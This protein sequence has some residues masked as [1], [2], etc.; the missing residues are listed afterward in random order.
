MIMSVSKKWFS[1]I[2]WSL[3]LSI[4][5]APVAMAADYS[6]LKKK[7]YRTSSLT[8]NRGGSQGWIVSM[9]SERYFCRLITTIV[10]VDSKTMLAF[11]SSGSAIPLDRA[12]FENSAGSA[13]GKFPLWSD[14]KNGRPE[15]RDVG[16]CSKLK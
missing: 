3:T 5:S 15:K 11:S 14:I 12:T 9:G 6:G 8:K 16:A 13:E 4:M 7:G 10:I 2:L 1:L